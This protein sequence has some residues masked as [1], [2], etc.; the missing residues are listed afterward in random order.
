MNSVQSKVFGFLPY[1][2]GMIKLVTKNG[3]HVELKVKRLAP[4]L[5]QE[6]QAGS[7][8]GI[9]TAQNPSI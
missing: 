3:G 7:Q 2:F 1:C 9:K 4:K 5:R 6:N 8:H